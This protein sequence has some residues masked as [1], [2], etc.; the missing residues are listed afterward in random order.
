MINLSICLIKISV[1]HAYS[2]KVLKPHMLNIIKEIIFPIM[3]YS[4]TDEDLYN[5]DTTEYIRQKFGK[6]FIIF[7]FWD[8]FNE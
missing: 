1:A 6:L 2:W 5:N 7:F 3:Q 8:I 4:E